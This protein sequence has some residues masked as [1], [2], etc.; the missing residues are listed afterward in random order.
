MMMEAGLARRMRV[1]RLAAEIRVARYLLLRQRHTAPLNGGWR[2]CRICGSFV[3][4]DMYS[5]TRHL[6]RC[7]RDAVRRATVEVVEEFLRKHG[8]IPVSVVDGVWPPDGDPPWRRVRVGR[9]EY[10][11]LG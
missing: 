2:V 5:V 10:Y 3:R 1:H 6:L 9:H 11:V 4:D 7:R 8:M